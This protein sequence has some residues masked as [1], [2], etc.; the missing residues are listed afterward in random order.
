LLGV[1]H[2]ETGRRERIDVGAQ[3]PEGILFSMKNNAPRFAF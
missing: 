3:C 1:L 2:F